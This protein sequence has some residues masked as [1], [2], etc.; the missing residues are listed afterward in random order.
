[1]TREELIIQGIEGYVERGAD[2]LDAVETFCDRSGVEIE[3]V[4]QV[5][6]RSTVFRE[7]LKEE[8]INKRLIE[9]DTFKGFNE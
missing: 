5:I 2:Y 7:K 1:M 6:K 4:A 9:D 8:A 3:L